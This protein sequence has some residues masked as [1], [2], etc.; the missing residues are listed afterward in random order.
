MLEG[1]NF[2]ISL[3][4]VLEVCEVW[5]SNLVL[6]GMMLVELVA[7]LFVTELGKWVHRC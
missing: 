5:W 3:L 7:C 6:E 2:E 1:F 4:N